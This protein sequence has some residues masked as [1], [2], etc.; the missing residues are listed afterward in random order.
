MVRW[1]EL[2]LLHYKVVQL[3]LEWLALQL[4]MNLK[5]D[6]YKLSSQ[7]KKIKRSSKSILKNCL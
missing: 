5:R 6:Q 2:K 3:T 7:L 1:I 4:Q